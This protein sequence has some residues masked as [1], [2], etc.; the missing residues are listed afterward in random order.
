MPVRRLGLL[1]PIICLLLLA[2]CGIANGSDADQTTTA[3][4]GT[5]AETTTTL[6]QSSDPDQAV[7]DAVDATLGASSFA[8]QGEANLQIGTQAFKLRTKGPVD[9]EELVADV[10]I[11]GGGSGQDA[12]VKLR[13][14]GT[15]LWVQAEGT[16]ADGVDLP[17][18]KTWIEGDAQRLE[19]AA[20]FDTAGLVGV[21]LALRASDGATEVGS[22]ELD[23]VE[24]T[25]YETTVDY[26]DAVAAAGDDVESFKSALSLTAPDPIALDITVS[27]GADGIIREFSLEV[28]SETA[29]LVG[30]YSLDLTDV[31]QPVDKPDAPADDEI[32]RGPEAEKILDDILK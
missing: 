4:T 13:A 1:T 17:V 14:D 2:G 20:T 27:V 31:N 26:D 24:V 32:L 16:A 28:N 22:T 30:D 8:V 21:V 11:S 7:I 5:A 12:A 10:E 29:G 15:D 9:Y 3:P 25:R 18:G 23:G 6:E 19:K